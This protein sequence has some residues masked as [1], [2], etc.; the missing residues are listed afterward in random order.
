MTNG[1]ET[2][3]RPDP[4]QDRGHASQRGIVRRLTDQ[5]DLARPGHV[6]RARVTQIMN[7]LQLAPDIQESILFLPNTV[8]GKDPIQEHQIRPI[9]ATPDWGKQ[10]QRWNGLKSNKYV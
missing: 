5:A 6:T 3:R 1:A 10:R 8:R 9:A 7:L 4:R 2:A